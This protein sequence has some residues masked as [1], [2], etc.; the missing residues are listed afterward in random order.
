MSSIRPNC[1]SCFSYLVATKVCPCGHRY[2]CD[3]LKKMVLIGLND[4]SLLP[5]KCCG[6][7]IDIDLCIGV[8]DISDSIKYIRA[9]EEYR[10][11]NKMYW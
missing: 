7:E 6:K 3:C 11:L 10:I 9:V 2:C 5:I 1:N 4:R 8:V